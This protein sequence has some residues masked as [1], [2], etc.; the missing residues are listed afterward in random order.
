M[1]P[2]K[3]TL[4]T[5]LISLLSVFLIALVIWLILVFLSVTTG[6]ENNWIS[7]LTAIHAPLKV[8]PTPKYYQSYYYQIDRFASHSNY[9]LKTIGEKKESTS[10]D[11]YDPTIDWELPPFL[12]EKTA[13]EEKK[14]LVK[15]IYEA[16]THL[17]KRFSPLFFQDYEIA[18]A[19]MRLSLQEENLF[20]SSAKRSFLSQ[21]TYLASFPGKNPHLSSLIEPLSS[22]DLNYLLSR[23][24]CIPSSWQRDLP[25][26]APL[27][28]EEKNSYLR[29]FFFHIKLQKVK[30]LADWRV[31]WDSVSSASLSVYVDPQAATFFLELPHSSFSK[32]TLE[33]R[34][35]N[36]WWKE[37]EQKLSQETPLFLGNSQILQAE[38]D[39]SSLDLAKD[40][41]EIL[42][43]FSCSLPQG[44]VLKGKTSFK[45]LQIYQATPLTRFSKTP[46]PSPLWPYSYQG[47]YHLPKKNHVYGILLPK[48]YRESGAKLGDIGYFSFLSPSA[49]SQQEMRLSFFIAGFYDPGVMPVGNRFAFVP[50]EVTRLM[51]ASSSFPSY[52]EEPSNGI[53]LWVKDHSQAPQIKAE[54]LS[55]LKEKKLDPYWKV[56]SYQDY[57]FSKSLLQ[58][59]QS[60]KT[61]FLL[62]A[63]LMILVACSNI[64]SFL[65][66]LVR[67]KR[68][69]IAI[70]KAL[71]TSSQSI[72]M[73]FGLCGILMGLFSCLLGTLAAIFTLKYLDQVVA[74]LSY[75]QGHAAFQT[76]FF[77]ESLPNE[78][79]TSILRLIWIITPILSFLA[80][81][82]P[83]VQAFRIHP[84]TTLRGDR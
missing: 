15:E 53:F 84:S 76:A 57:S 44:V 32:A 58:Q 13:S 14:D 4:S 51:N 33:K 42:L 18:G 74:F 48:T 3:R 70:L 71:G 19:L 52:T 81:C 25:Q 7:K 83:A 77:G 49:T 2:K 78:I 30:A 20:S 46:H 73:I 38:V 80:G 68:K 79:S 17:E 59:F 64:I 72:L 27:T 65:I 5:S 26:K 63:I 39:L 37:K 21:A 23:W 16:L 36:W 28:E 40:L 34:G 47:E 43:H 69:E 8:Y 31:P 10:M 12:I 75:L 66:L 67:D 1:W 45:H 55:L 41:S 50:S 24:D 56:L 6:I 54:L 22:Q 60:D 9:S 35:E 29:S 61:L 82:I 62:L 11:P